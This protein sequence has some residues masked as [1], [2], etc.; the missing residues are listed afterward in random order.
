MASGFSVSQLAKAH[1]IEEMQR[2]D[3]KIRQEEY[4]KAHPEGFKNLE[5]AEESMQYFFNMIENGWVN[6]FIAG[7]SAER[8]ERNGGY[9]EVL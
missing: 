3:E 5:T 7:I 6:K 8:S 9:Y 1:Y 2:I 4:R